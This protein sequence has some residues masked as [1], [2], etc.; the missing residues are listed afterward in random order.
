MCLHW[1][2]EQHAVI[3]SS[4][5]TGLISL[6]FVLTSFDET[7]FTELINFQ[8]YFESIYEDLLDQ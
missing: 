7:N 4:I 5:I 1:Y 3:E 8:K 6:F 2:L